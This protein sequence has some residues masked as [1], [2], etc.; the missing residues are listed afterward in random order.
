MSP[1]PPSALRFGESVRPHL[2]AMH[3]AARAVVHSDDLAWDA[4]QVAL[5]R[6]WNRGPEPPYSRAYLQRAAQLAG[7]GIQRSA[8]RRCRHE[9]G[10]SRARCSWR[11]RT[12]LE[13]ALA[14]R[15]TPDRLAALLEHLPD[16]C[17]EVLELRALHEL[18]YDVIARNLDIPIGT[19]RSRLHR[20][21][22]ILKKKVA[23]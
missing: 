8:R 14:E 22:R 4:V 23:A 12:H 20:A 2:G 16:E 13:D 17:R 3:R 7:L 19:V 11:R 10:A 15:Q 5:L 1:T 18:P 6:L 9:D 21:R